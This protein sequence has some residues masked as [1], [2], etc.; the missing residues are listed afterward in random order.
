L[1]EARGYLSQDH[2]L[3]NIVHKNGAVAYQVE[4]TRFLV[5]TGCYI[6]IIPDH[7]AL[8]WVERGLLYRIPLAEFRTERPRVLG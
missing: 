3:E 4:A 8:P 5:L 1:R 2:L 6:G 7:V